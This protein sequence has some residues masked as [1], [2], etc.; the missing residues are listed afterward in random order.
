MTTQTTTSLPETPVEP[1]RSRRAAHRRPV[2][3]PPAA[4]RP[5]RPRTR[6]RFAPRTVRARI[7]SLLAL[8]VVSLTALWG[9]AA[10]NTISAAYNQSQLKAIDSAVAA[11][12]DITVTALQQERTEADAY[13]AVSGNPPTTLNA[14]ISASR[15]AASTLRLNIEQSAA[16][17]ADLSPQLAA[18]LAT[19]RQAM[20]AQTAIRTG[21]IGH[22]LSVASANNA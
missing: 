3:P 2:D 18:R 17:A 5:A 10:V 14:R 12:L 21:I 4:L 6:F 19:T 11:Q 22:S 7:V 8:P 20:D 13:L 9:I 1:R 16:A 15:N